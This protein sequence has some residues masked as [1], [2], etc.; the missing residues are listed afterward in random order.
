MRTKKIWLAV[1]AMMMVTA[2]NGVSYAA[3]TA[4][5]ASINRPWRV[6]AAITDGAAVDFGV[7]RTLRE[8]LAVRGE[9]GKGMSDKISRVYL[10]GRT[11]GGHEGMAYAEAGLEQFSS[12]YGVNT[13]GIRLGVGIEREI[14]ARNPRFI[15]GMGI[16]YH[17]A[18]LGDTSSFG[19]RVMA[20]F[21]F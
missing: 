18:P 11:Y 13:T 21:T 9:I 15:S 2:W 14:F 10:G 8:G 6:D 7:M 5:G 16:E 19:L 3:D 1:V 12:R 17:T 4:A 20:G